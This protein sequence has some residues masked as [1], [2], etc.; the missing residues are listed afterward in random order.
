MLQNI[1]YLDEIDHIKMRS[2]GSSNPSDRA[3]EA[4]C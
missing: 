2:D 4:Y 1:A 3:F